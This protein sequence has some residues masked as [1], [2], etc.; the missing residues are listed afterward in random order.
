MRY[1]RN[2]RYGFTDDQRKLV[3]FIKDTGIKVSKKCCDI[4]KKSPVKEYIKKHAID[5]NV[6]GERKA[7]GGLRA[8][9][10]KTCFTTDKR[11]M[12][13]FMPIFWWDAE[14]KEVFKLAEGITYSD[15]YEVYGM[16]RTGCVGCPFNV[17]IGDDL[18][19][20]QKYEPR[21][22]AACMNVFG[23]SY[24]LTDRFNC[25]RKKIL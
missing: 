7:E 20:I 4:S 15:C 17:H 8:N 23:L 16:K 6:T 14:C 25:R 10:H 12:D 3:D 11:G 21:L 19:V 5:L 2:N 18:K 24:E 9:A 22:Y 1:N 13:K